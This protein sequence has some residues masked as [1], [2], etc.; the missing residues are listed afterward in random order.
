MPGDAL[1]EVRLRRMQLGL[2]AGLVALGVLV[3]RFPPAQYSFYPV[4]PIH[5]LT[6]LQ[7]P[8][9]GA[10]RALAALVRGEF[11][12]A[13]GLNALFCAVVLPGFI[14]WLVV[15]MRKGRWVGVPA[16]LV[17]GFAVVT[18]AFTVWRNC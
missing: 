8:G 7:C 5:A 14:L 1:T 6:G 16:A 12:L 10:T 17:Y 13:F 2:V 15:S 3:S 18:V 11:G 9:C 4:C